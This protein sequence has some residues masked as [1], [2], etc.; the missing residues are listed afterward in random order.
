MD[1]KYYLIYET[2]NNVNGKIYRGA[3][4]TDRVDDGYLGS[5]D[6][7]KKAIKKYGKDSFTRKVLKFCKDNDD[8]YMWEAYFV[9]KTF[10]GND[11]SYNLKVGGEGGACEGEK[12]P[13]YGKSHSDETK[14]II[15][16]SNRGRKPTESHI[17]KMRDLHT[18]VPRSKDV[19]DKISK[20]N[21][22]ERNGMYGNNHSKQTRLKM[23]ESRKGVPQRKIECPHCNQIGGIPGM[24]RYHFDNC[25]YNG[26]N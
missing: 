17:Q 1:S 2:V 24:K 6:L 4:S 16:E 26:G 7:L 22:G 5:G 18:G 14:R 15:S 10:V 25:K 3:H 23:S 12:N 9:P 11:M 21:S 8:M 13:F 19:K 20:A